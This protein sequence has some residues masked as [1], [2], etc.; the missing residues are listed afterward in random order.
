MSNILIRPGWVLEIRCAIDG[1]KQRTGASDKHI[2]Q[3]VH[4][5]P[6]DKASLVDHAKSLS[7]HKSWEPRQQCHSMN[8]GI[9]RFIQ[10]DFVMRGSNPKKL[11]QS[12]PGPHEHWVVTQACPAKR[13]RNF[14]MSFEFLPHQP[15]GEDDDEGPSDCLATRQAL[16]AAAALFAVRVSSPVIVFLMTFSLLYTKPFPSPSPSPITPVVVQSRVPRTTLILVFLSL[17]ALS[18]LIDGLAY[19]T[20]AV[21]NRAWRLGTGIP[22]ASVLGLV[23]Y[24]GVAALGAWKDINNVQVWFLTRVRLV[25]AIIRKILMK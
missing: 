16:G 5:V 22:L 14:L 21:F 6:A 12:M 24:T 2:S 19:I 1:R 11:N 10:D 17:S 15:G 20:Y 3:F 18:F 8:E 25:I 9:Y 23:T 13:N 4:S 7:H